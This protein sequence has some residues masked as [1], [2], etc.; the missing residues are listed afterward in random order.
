MIEGYHFWKGFFWPLKSESGQTDS[1]EIR[2]L[3]LQLWSKMLNLFCA[4]HVLLQ[5][6]P[7]Q[8]KTGELALGQK[9]WKDQ[10]I[11]G[12]ETKAQLSHSQM[13]SDETHNKI[14][15]LHSSVNRVGLVTRG[16][17]CLCARTCEPEERFAERRAAVLWSRG[18]PGTRGEAGSQGPRGPREPEKLPDRGIIVLQRLR[19]EAAG[20]EVQAT[21]VAG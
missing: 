5:G 20:G 12:Q 7:G 10:A 13:D 2:Y 1:D 19:S 14:R 21:T 15:P 4:P 9:Q 18:H 3:L 17:H 8:R 16:K 6:V 11:P